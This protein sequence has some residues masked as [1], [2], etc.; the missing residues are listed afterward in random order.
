MISPRRIKGTPHKI[1]VRVGLASQKK[2]KAKNK[3]SNVR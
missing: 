3:L 1:E 2:I